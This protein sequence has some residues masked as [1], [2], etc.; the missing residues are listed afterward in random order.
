MSVGR[1]FYPSQLLFTQRIS[2]VVQFI[3][4]FIHLR[5][6]SSW[7][8]ACAATIVFQSHRSSAMIIASEM[9]TS[10]IAFETTDSQEFR[11]LPG[12]LFHCDGGGEI[13]RLVSLAVPDIAA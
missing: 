1:S 3:H 9:L 13:A 4:S 5:S 11:G 12:G 10:F 8:V 2:V 7:D 6:M